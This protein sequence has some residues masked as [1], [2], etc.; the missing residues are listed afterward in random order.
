MLEEMEIQLLFVWHK[1]FLS[2]NHSCFVWGSTSVSWILEPFLIL[3][4]FNS[5]N[6]SD[7][8]WK[9]VFSWHSERNGRNPT[10]APVDGWRS[11]HF[12]GSG[13]LS[14]TNSTVSAHFSDV[15]LYL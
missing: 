6:H 12:F 1:K 14:T 7:F 8:L 2:V 5:Q 10:V 13:W 3:L 4:T 15:H 9:G 11:S